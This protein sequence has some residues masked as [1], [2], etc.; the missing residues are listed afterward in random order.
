MLVTRRPEREGLQ[1]AQSKLPSLPTAAKTPDIVFTATCKWFTGMEGK[2]GGWKAAVSELRRA[3]K[4]VG[5]QSALANNR[6][7]FDVD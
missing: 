5:P 2:M 3:L 6:S 4:L 7:L 1:M